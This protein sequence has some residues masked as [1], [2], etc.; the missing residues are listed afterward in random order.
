MTVT[1]IRKDPRS[2]TLTLEAEFDAS[3]SASGSCGAIRD[4]SNAGRDRRPT[5][6][7]SLPMTRVPA[8][9]SNTTS[10]ARR[11]PSHAVAWNVEV[12]ACNDFWTCP[13]SGGEQVFQVHLRQ[14]MSHYPTTRWP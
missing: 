9:K 6:R 7:R 2:R 14:Q 13:A 3:K 10:P 4:S 8:A 12:V 5:Q 1:A 11:A